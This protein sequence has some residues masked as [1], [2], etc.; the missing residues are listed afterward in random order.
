MKDPSINADL[1]LQNND[2]LFVPVAQ[3]IVSI[4]GSVIRPMKYEITEK[5]NLINLIDFAGG[6][7]FDARPDY[8]K[9]SRIVDGQEELF[10]YDLEKILDGKQSVELK[11]GDRISISSI[12]RPFEN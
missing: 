1:S 2:I 3:K 5:E 10:E 11:N 4:Q 9:I 12:K 8:V 7:R 6:I